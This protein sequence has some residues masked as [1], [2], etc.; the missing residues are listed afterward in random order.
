MRRLS[1]L[2][3][4]AFAMISS[5]LVNAQSAGAAEIKVLCGGA[6]QPAFS[7]LIPKFEQSTGHKVTIAYDNIGALTNRIKNGEAADVAIVSPAQVDD[8]QKQGRVVAGSQV[9]VAKA[10]IGVF[11]RAGNPKP[12]ISSPEAFTRA[13]LAARSVGFS[14]PASGSPVGIY[15]TAL[16]ERLGIADQMRQ[17]NKYLPNSSSAEHTASIKS[18][19]VEFGFAPVAELVKEPGVQLVGPLPASIQNYTRFSAGVVADS[20]NPDAAKAFITFITSPLARATLSTK[21]LET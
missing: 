9:D 21:G 15:M 16:V 11:T 6:L 14:E 13:L 20:K 2:A 7:E 17:K 5:L 12:D 3:A 19:E 1:T 8:L 10:G 4:I 18:G